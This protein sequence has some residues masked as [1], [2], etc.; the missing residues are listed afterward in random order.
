MT[1]GDRFE[2]HLFLVGFMGSG[3]STVARL[4]ASAVARDRVGLTE[5]AAAGMEMAAHSVSHPDLGLHPDNVVRDQS[6]AGRKIREIF[7]ADGEDAFR[8]LETAALLSLEHEPPSVVACGGG[9]V[10][11]PENRAA[12]RRMGAVVYLSVTAAEAL[13]RIHDLAT[14]PLLSGGAGALAA[15]DL[16]AAREGLYRSVADAVVDTG[17]KTPEQV[18]QAVVAALEA[19]P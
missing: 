4:V 10:L 3:K 16:L 18:A 14:R 7:D 15:T 6:R 1:A 9:I 12:L 2:R 5:M 19:L 8:G 17:G 11:K 13:A